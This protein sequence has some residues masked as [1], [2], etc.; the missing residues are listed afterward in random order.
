MNEEDLQLAKVLVG[1][2]LSNSD[3]TMKKSVVGKVKERVFR[4]DITLTK[5]LTSI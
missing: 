1:M 2:E 4:Y 5:W 3:P